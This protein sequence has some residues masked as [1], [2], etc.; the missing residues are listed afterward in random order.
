MN[1][2]VVGKMQHTHSSKCA[3]ISE[4]GNISNIVP[5]SSVRYLGTIL[6]PAAVAQCD[7]ILWKQSRYIYML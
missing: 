1:D 2:D 4:K 5:T 7:K 6:C 3:G